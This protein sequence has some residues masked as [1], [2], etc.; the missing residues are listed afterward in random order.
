MFA[1]LSRYSREKGL[2]FLEWT[3]NRNEITEPNLFTS[4]ENHNSESKADTARFSLLNEFDSLCKKGKLGISIN[5][6]KYLWTPDSRNPINF[7]NYEVQHKEDK[8]P[9]KGSA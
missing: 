5:Q 4:D 9:T 2:H 1:G 8:A 6:R 7:W 3:K